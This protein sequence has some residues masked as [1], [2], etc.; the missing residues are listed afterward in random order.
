[1]LKP[2]NTW[3]NHRQ[4]AEEALRHLPDAAG[5]HSREI[6]EGT[7]DRDAARRRAAELE[8]QVQQGGSTEA[9]MSALVALG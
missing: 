5:D 1:M 7:A 8:D 3:R 9:T 6:G 2:M 4:R